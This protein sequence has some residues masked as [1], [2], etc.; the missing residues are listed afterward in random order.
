M[1]IKWEKKVQ[2][3]YLKFQKHDHIDLCIPESGLVVNPRWPFICASP[4]DIVTCGCC[5]TRVLEIKCPYSHWF[6][7][8]HDAVLEDTSFCL[9]EEVDGMLK[10]DHSH[11]YYHQIQTQLFVCDLNS[12]DFCVCTFFEDDERNGLH[13]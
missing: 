9:K 8:I 12:C 6:K 11:A 4:E 5:K 13:I 10:C 1:G 3:L 2:E 7:A